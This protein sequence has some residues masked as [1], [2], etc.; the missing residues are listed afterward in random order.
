MTLKEEHS[1]SS[2]DGVDEEA[3]SQL[4]TSLTIHHPQSQPAELTRATNAATAEA[5]AEATAQEGCSRK[6]N[7]GD[8]GD[9][10]G[11]QPRSTRVKWGE[12]YGGSTSTVHYSFGIN[13]REKRVDEQLVMFGRLHRLVL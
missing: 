1:A 7:D 5:T 11:V 4:Y 10:N 2:H 3:L 6:S 9:K 8:G 13:E 12:A